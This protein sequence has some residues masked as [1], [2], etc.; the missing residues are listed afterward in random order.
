MPGTTFERLMREEY[1][2]VL[3]VLARR[4]GDLDLAEEVL[5]EALARAAER[6]PREG[7]PE[8]PAAWLT[9]VARNLLIDRARST[10][11]EIEWTDAVAEQAQEVAAEAPAEHADFALED[12]R[13]R[14]LFVCCHPSLNQES[15]M[16]LALRTLCGLTTR[17][18]ARAFVQDESATAQ[19]LVRAKRKIR[20]ARIP[21]EVPDAAQLPERIDT[22][23]AVIYLLF[24]EGYLAHETEPPVRSDLCEQAIRLGKL[25]CDLVRRHV[26][27]QAL[28]ALMLLQHA[29]RAARVCDGELVPMEDQD[30]SLWHAEDIRAGLAW[31]DDAIACHR[32]QGCAPRP[33]LLQAAIAALHNRAS[34][35]EQTDWLQIAS[36]Y[37]GLLEVLPSPVVELNGA[38]AH[39][40]AQGPQE[41][42][43][44]IARLEARG[45]LSGYHLLPAAQADL[46]RRAGDI[47]GARDAY[48]RA[49]GLATQPLE[50]RFLERRLHE[51][52]A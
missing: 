7:E 22:V 14:L 41:G 30:R 1:G 9:T 27:A 29:R 2:K 50:R 49:L 24:N 4:C 44:R 26:E 37:D 8:R 31:L 6:W 32:A 17:E 51:L 45:E 25:A 23:L 19:R 16:A 12:D 35:S 43:R 10:P 52:A 38:V 36:L 15:Q 20:E 5:S 28:V 33:Y 34:A 13:L 18:I 11:L 42:L 3:A 46:L 39:A 40:M 48:A 47:A 21:F